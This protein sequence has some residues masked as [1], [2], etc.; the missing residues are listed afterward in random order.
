[1]NF[2]RFYKLAKSSEVCG[3][4]GRQSG[5]FLLLVIYLL[6]MFSSACAAQDSGAA[7]PVPVVSESASSS[8]SG[9]SEA[10]LPAVKNQS[11]SVKTAV[12]VTT[13]TMN[14]TESGKYRVF[15]Q[16]GQSF[17][18]VEVKPGVFLM[19]SANQA[20]SEDDEE[21][22]SLASTVE[23]LTSEASSS[24]SE[25]TNEIMDPDASSDPFQ[26]LPRSSVDD[27]DSEED[28]IPHRVEISRGILV[29]TTEVTQGIYSAVTGT[30]PSGFRWSGAD[31]P[32]E[33]VSWFDAVL[34][35]NKLSKIMNLNPCYDEKT[36]RCNFKANG[37]RLPTEAEWEYMTRAG[38]PEKFSFGN[39]YTL[40]NQYAV[41]ASSELK[42]PAPVGT[43]KPNNWGI[44]DVH[45]NVW[46]WCCDVYAYDYDID[47]VKDPVN[48][49]RPLTIW[50]LPIS[51]QTQLIVNQ[52]STVSD[53]GK[54]KSG[55]EEE[56]EPLTRVIRG[57]GWGSVYYDCRSANRG[58]AD[59]LG[60]YN[61][62]GFRVVRQIP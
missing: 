62:V 3:N 53:K 44:K 31:Y 37:F 28:E 32:V 45:G 21:E 18:M 40:L 49:G 15:F 24:D 1:M 8:S 7:V 26:S 10:S 54:G 30:N 60:N 57:G 47:A 17:E 20:P 16:D 38:N 42:T 39:D 5:L 36:Y 35:C 6:I 19:G 12:T 50:E 46:E 52:D 43:R 61:D 23:T 56:E 25:V 51:S 33:Q 59:P 2:S 4:G 34:F 27:E 9:I 22:Q 58:K 48:L 29:S 13:A 14:S 55:D 11:A 41:V